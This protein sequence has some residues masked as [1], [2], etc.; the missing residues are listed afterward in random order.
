MI[1]S[2]QKQ[3]AITFGNSIRGQYIIGQALYYAIKAL[4]DVPKPF[5]EI[6]NISDMD[7]IRKNLYNFPDDVYD[8]PSE[9]KNL[10]HK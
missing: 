1:Q 5:R 7:Y 4:E 10:W 9:V 2:D 8:I 6:S 3:E